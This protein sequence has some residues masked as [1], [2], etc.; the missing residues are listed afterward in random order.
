M[1]KT[2]T[3]IS[4]IVVAVVAVAITTNIVLTKKLP[5]IINSI[6]I[7]KAEEALGLK[8]TLGDAKLH[9]FGGKMTISKVEIS[10]PDLADNNIVLYMDEFLVNFSLLPLLGQKIEISNVNINDIKVNI[11]RDQNGKLNFEPHTPPTASTQSATRTAVNQEKPV[12][13]VKVAKKEKKSNKSAPLKLELQNFNCSTIITYT[14][15]KVS[16]PPL[17]MPFAATLAANNITTIGSDEDEWGTFTIKGS[18]LDKPKVFET[19][20]TGKIAPITDPLKVSMSIDGS[21]TGIDLT[22]LG[23]YTNEIDIAAENITATF[24]LKCDGGNIDVLNSALILT[25]DNVTLSGKL[26]QQA[27]NIS[28]PPT[29]TINVPIS[30]TIDAP[31]IDI[32]AAIIMTVL[33]NLGGTLGTMLENATIDG[34]KLDGD[35]GEAAKVLGNFLKGF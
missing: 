25:M 4:I 18:L 22:E 5:N 1:N 14:D 2:V 21:I 29:L 19:S 10:N 17:T 12:A 3:I 27:K 33:K 31:E 11:N 7:P 16:T 8:I 6:V 13:E 28:L 23:P 26:A 15:E 24:K 32:T 35:L 34:K 20:I 9:L 30:G